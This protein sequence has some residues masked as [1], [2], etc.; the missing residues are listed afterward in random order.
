MKQLHPHA[1]QRQSPLQ[2][3]FTP[4][5]LQLEVIWPCENV[6]LYLYICKT[7]VPK[8]VGMCLNTSA[9]NPHSSVHSISIFKLFPLVPAMSKVPLSNE[10]V[11]WA[12][13][14]FQRTVFLAS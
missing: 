5:S 8:L 6:K 10:M 12:L 9:R 13:P 14:D 11:A 7:L 4:S 1:C 3:P 2:P